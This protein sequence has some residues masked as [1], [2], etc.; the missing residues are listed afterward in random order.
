MILTLMY[1]ELHAG[2]RVAPLMRHLG[3]DLEREPDRCVG[4]SASECDMCMW[5]RDCCPKTLTAARKDLTRIAIDLVGI[6]KGAPK[7]LTPKRLADVLLGSVERSVKVIHVGIE[8]S[9]CHGVLKA[10]RPAR[11][12]ETSSGSYKKGGVAGSVAMD[13]VLL[14]VERGALGM[15]LK[16]YGPHRTWGLFVTLGACA[17]QLLEGEMTIDVVVWEAADGPRP[18][19]V[20]DGKQDRSDLSAQLVDTF[21][22]QP[23]GAATVAAPWSNK[24]RT[25]ASANDAPRATRLCLQTRRSLFIVPFRAELDQC[26][27]RAIVLS[28]S[29]ASVAVAVALDLLRTREGRGRQSI[30]EL[31]AASESLEGDT[32]HLL[33]AHR[34]EFCDALIAEVDSET[35]TVIDLLGKV[36]D[37]TAN[38]EQLADLL[39]Q[40]DA[41]R[42]QGWSKVVIE[43]GKSTTTRFVLELMQWV[44]GVPI[45]LYN[46]RGDKV[47]L[48]RGGGI[49]VPDSGRG[50]L[51]IVVLEC[52]TF[53][54]LRSTGPAG[55]GAPDE[56]DASAVDAPCPSTPTKRSDPSAWT[57]MHSPFR[58]PPGAQLL[59]VGARVEVG[60][61]GDAL[62][63]PA[64]R[65]ASV[66]RQYAASL[67][68]T[69]SHWFL[70]KSGVSKSW[71][72]RLRNV[73]PLM[74]PPTEVGGCIG[75]RLLNLW[76]ELLEARFASVCVFG[77]NELGLATLSG[78]TDRLVANIVRRMNA[79]L[80]PKATCHMF[81]VYCPSD[82]AATDGPGHWCYVAVRLAPS[83]NASGMFTYST[84]ELFWPTDDREGEWRVN[85]WCVLLGRALAT[86]YDAVTWMES[87]G[88]VHVRNAR[89]TAVAAGRDPCV[90]EQ[91][92]RYDC[93]LFVAISQLCCCHGADPLISQ[94]DLDCGEFR[95]WMFLCVVSLSLLRTKDAWFDARI[96]SGDIGATAPVS[97]TG[98][99]SPPT[100]TTTR[101]HLPS[102]N[103]T[104][105]LEGCPSPLAS[106]VHS[107][108]A[109]PGS[110]GNDDVQVLT[111]TS[112]RTRTHARA[113]TQTPTTNLTNLPVLPHT[114]Q[115][116]VHLVVGLG[117]LRHLFEM[118]TS[119]PCSDELV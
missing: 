49:A 30:A 33:L 55:S 71:E 97:P 24:T 63:S 37:N 113:S 8:R 29:N 15:E 65:L 108:N 77:R 92:R 20:E 78:D 13:V 112:A 115:L 91:T 83:A 103:T 79:R 66:D 67:P 10:A 16:Q 118:E 106:A 9:V 107:A 19:G 93:G 84:A 117:V 74:T 41:R 27:E 98:G 70:L 1:L 45:V 50:V 114:H 88:G 47:E 4:C 73:L 68:R 31:R 99:S 111:R 3:V 90:F 32:R 40:M 58:S 7:Q 14:L 81:T 105:W 57:T 54:P 102:P 110:A 76:A 26:N 48:S 86:V 12:K 35:A 34:L 6:V 85:E 18:R 104:A 28:G 36:A 21:C 2:C 109:E 82:D 89:S 60:G 100:A 43:F 96:R 23:V 42:E 69:V 22:L 75:R 51:Q 59:S 38:H 53:L 46:A 87:P 94:G 5:T 80:P 116:A 119:F 39:C 56:A 64:F 72:V 61:A 95:S 17:R 11:Y 62:T 44:A 52:G 101:H 25:R